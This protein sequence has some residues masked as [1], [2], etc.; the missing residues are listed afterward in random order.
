MQFGGFRGQTFKWVLENALGY[1]AWLVDSMRNETATPSPISQH[2]FSFKA[3]AELFP[4]CREV[5]AIKKEERLKK[6][7]AKLQ[8]SGRSTPAS[9]S[10]QVKASSSSAVGTRTSGTTRTSVRST[11]RSTTHTASTVASLLQRNASPHRICAVLSRSLAGSKQGSVPNLSL[12]GRE[13]AVCPSK[14]VQ[15]AVRNVNPLVHVTNIS[16]SQSHESNDEELCS[17][18]DKVE[19]ELGIYMSISQILGT[20][21]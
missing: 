16:P 3:Y 5:I 13:P 20:T 1:A 6:T 11:P 18:A 19:H 21:A 8:R 12:S 4:E 15:P 7:S 17:I 14:Q 2:K 10:M 9:V